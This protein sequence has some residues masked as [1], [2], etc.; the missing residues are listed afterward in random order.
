M[1]TFHKEVVIANDGLP[2]NMRS[3]VNHH[4][5]TNDIIVADNQLTLL[6]TEFKVLRG[7]AK[8][9]PLVYFI[10]IT[11]MGAIQ[12]TGKWEDDTIVTYHHI[13]LNIHEWVYLAIVAD[14]RSCVDFGFWTYIVCHIFKL[15]V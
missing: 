5:F 11:H 15:I 12:D 14:F 1:N 3:T 9:C 7:C 4:V 8:N 2:A 10:I 6:T 13:A